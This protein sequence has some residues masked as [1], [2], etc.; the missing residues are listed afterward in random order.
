MT[1]H[2]IKY[3]SPELFNSIEKGS[4]KLKEPYNLLD[5]SED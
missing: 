1:H 3:D 5:N 2:I 4:F